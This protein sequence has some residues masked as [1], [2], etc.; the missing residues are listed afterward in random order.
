VR[1]LGLI[2]GSGLRRKGFLGPGKEVDVKTPHGPPS[3]PLWI[4]QVGRTAVAFLPR[5]G[6]GRPIPPH[7]INHRANLW[8]LH[9]AGARS[10]FST[11]SVGSLKREIRPGTLVVP[12]DYFAPWQLVTFHDVE[13]KHVTPRLDPALRDRLLDAA[14]RARVKALDGGT[15]VQTVGPRLETRAEIR[16]FRNFGDVVGMTM[17]PEAT[18][19][20]ELGLRYAALCSV[21]NYAHGVTAVPTTFAGI[22]QEQ[23][24]N[25]E[26]VRAVLLEAFAGRAPKK[27]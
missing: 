15:Y 18:L 16:M 3:G 24:R 22:R 14:R 5:H 26:R 10:V 1:P 23:R 8:A 17:A 21:D 25:E 6:A 19:A 2:G 12:D 9:S 4:G 13:A 20:A 7:R 11:A 27:P